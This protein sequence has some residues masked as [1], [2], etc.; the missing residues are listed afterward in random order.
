M[1]FVKE[2][3]SGRYSQIC[4]VI[5]SSSLPLFVMSKHADARERDT[6]VLHC[7]ERVTST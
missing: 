1:L 5:P 3:D 4:S 6:G 7:D 2:I